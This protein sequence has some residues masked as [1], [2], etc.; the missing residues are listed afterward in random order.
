MARLGLVVNPTAGNG[1]GRQAGDACRR[2]LASDGHH[3]D[4]LSAE[5]AAHAERRGREAVGAGLDAIVVVG[6]DGMVGLGANIVAGTG[7]PLGVVAAGSGN[8]A[9][10]YAGLPI[11]DV[12]AAVAVIS[13]ALAE[14]SRRTMDLIE[15]R[16]DGPEP[17]RLVVGAVSCGVDAAVNA[18]ANRLR[19]PR[20]GAR[21]VRALAGILPGLRPYGF[22]VSADGQNWSQGAVLMMVAN[23]G[24][25]GGG[26]RIAPDADSSDGLLELVLAGAVTRTKLLRVFPRVYRGTHV[27]DPVVSV[28]RVTEVTLAHDASAGAVPPEA[29][30]DGEPIGELPVTCTVRPGAL[31]LLTDGGR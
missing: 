9:A 14:G 19:W 8:D 18:A 16:H 12:P 3:V 4:E 13:R 21:Y 24:R 7:V 26:M 27:T 10:A 17:A 30:G 1:R 6:G 23:T 29:F 22:S 15:V 20:G 2:L 25:I 28:R 31:N 11:R 5:D